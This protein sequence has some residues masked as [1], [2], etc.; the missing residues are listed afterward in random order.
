MRHLLSILCLALGIIGC[1]QAPK[2][3]KEPV[4]ETKEPVEE[5]FIN[6]YW[7]VDWHPSK[8]QIVVGGMV[9]KV[10][11]ISTT[12][13]EVMKEIPFPGT[14]TKTK[15]HPSENKL[16]ISVQDRKSFT[17]II[18]LETDE[19]I[20]LDS[21]CADGARAI[22]W[23]TQGDLLAVGDYEGVITF[24]DAKG[25]FIKNINTGQR[26][27]IGMDWHPN[28]N[29]VAAIGEKITIYNYENDS[30]YHINDR[31]EEIEVL[32]LCVA[33]H[34]SGKFFVTGDY[35]DFQNDYPPLL[36]YWSYNG[37]KIKSI[38]E[39]KAEYRNVAWAHNG[40]V[41][42]TASEKIRLWDTEGNLIA[43]NENPAR[44]WGIDWNSNGT[45]I[46]A[47]D[48]QCKIIFWDDNLNRLIE[49]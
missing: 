35:G 16:A 17:S 9:D 19:S 8:D 18:D 25:N 48:E 40:E 2:E 43:E 24:F 23:N 34:P 26:S 4:E 41:L 13:Y 11:V 28:Q 47:T 45:Q 32:M 30:M 7:A 22:D 14:V 38:I 42:A 46:V 44:L 5:T 1:K 29:L 12:D 49:K 21:V 31:E 6:H 39:S 33:W 36:Q 20:K 37:D 15:W 10:R 27:I 3:A